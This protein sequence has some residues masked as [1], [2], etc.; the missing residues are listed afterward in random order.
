MK[1]IAA[2]S[3]FGFKLSDKA[4]WQQR[5]E[6]GDAVNWTEDDLWD[7]TL[8]LMP[9]LKIKDP[10]LA[11]RVATEIVKL[12][13]IKES[14]G[15]GWG[16]AYLKKWLPDKFGIKCAKQAKQAAIFKSLKD[17]RIIRELSHG[18]KGKASRWSVGSRVLARL[19]GDE[20]CYAGMVATHK[21][22]DVS[23]MV[24]KEWHVS[25]WD[26]LEEKGGE[27]KKGSTSLCSLFNASK[28]A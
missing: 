7:I 3:K 19:D 17:L 10:E 20:R 5:S 6:T 9:A 24:E 15:K 13:Q 21:I 26:G 8:W 14:E 23:W 22:E 27:E 1:T 12:T 25:H 11:L 18:K 2:W 28:D 4:T 16:Y